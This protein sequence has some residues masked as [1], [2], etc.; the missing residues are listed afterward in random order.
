MKPLQS[1][2]LRRAGA[3]VIATA[4][5]ST[6]LLS[7]ATR[8]RRTPRVT[9]PCPPAAPGSRPSSP[10]ASSSA[11]TAREYGPSIDVGSGTGRGRATTGTAS[12]AVD[13]AFAE[14]STTTSRAMPSVTWT[15]RTPGRPARRPP[16]PSSPAPTPGR[17]AAWTSISRLE[18]VVSTAAPTAGRIADMSIYGD[19][20]NVI[21]QSFAARALTTVGSDLADEATSFLLEQQCG[22][23]FFRLRPD[24]GQDQCPAGLRHRRRRQRERPGRHR[25]RR[26]QPVG[27]SRASP[28]AIAA[29]RSGASWLETQQSA[30]GSFGAGSDDGANANTTG[31]AGW[32][33]GEAGRPRPPRR[34]PVG[35]RGSRSPT[36]RRASP[37]WRLRTAPSHPVRP[38]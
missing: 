3:L 7:V 4:I 6:T 5:T 10:T 21:G 25:D 32:A 37:P 34:R 20:A 9:A 16:S 27:H 8:R 35:S 12:A 18:D 29:A 11:S 24:R 15:A 22:A 36:W 30:D 28:S 31:L 13:T 19:Y 33:L 17:T 1:P 23:G 38:L 26:H 2:G 14:P